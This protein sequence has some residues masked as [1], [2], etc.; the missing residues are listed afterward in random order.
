MI[1]LVEGGDSSHSGAS[2]VSMIESIKEDD[3]VMETLP[4][5][6]GKN[7]AIAFIV[8]IVVV[9]CLLLVLFLGKCNTAPKSTPTAANLATPHG[10]TAVPST[11]PPMPLPI[12]SAKPKYTYSYLYP[13]H[14]YPW[15]EQEHRE[16]IQ[17]P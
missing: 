13:N 9:F 5:N 1:E 10:L 14:P 12:A 4:D 7:F 16:E 11:P 17:N 3:I 8:A 6:E 2:A 15:Q